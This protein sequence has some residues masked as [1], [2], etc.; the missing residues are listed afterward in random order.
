MR[1][2]TKRRLRTQEELVDLAAARLSSPGVGFSAG[3]TPGEWTRLMFQGFFLAPQM[4]G[5]ARKGGYLTAQLLA[6]EGFDVRPPTGVC[7]TAVALRSRHRLLRF[8]KALMS[9]RYDPRT[10][11]TDRAGNPGST[12][13]DH[14]KRHRML[15]SAPAPGPASSPRVK[16]THGERGTRGLVVRDADALTMARGAWATVL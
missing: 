6:R 15:S 8:C 14:G 13:D 4:V 12:H 1:A 3:A 11:S 9:H 2:L 10:R 7:V 5:E 16:S